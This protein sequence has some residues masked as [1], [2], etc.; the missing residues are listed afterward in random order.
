MENLIML[1]PGA[2][3]R[4][5]TQAVG[6]AALTG[7][8][9][10]TVPFPSDA[11]LPGMR[12]VEAGA[13]P[14]EVRAVFA[15]VLRCTQRQQL[16]S[17][18]APGQALVQVPSQ[19]V[20]A[21]A[22]A[23]LAVKEGD[24]SGEEAQHIQEGQDGA[25]AAQRS[26]ARRG[27]RAPDEPVM[28]AAT[29][30]LPPVPP[31]LM[32][33]A[34][35]SEPAPEP[36]EASVGNGMTVTAVS[37]SSATHSPAMTV[38]SGAVG[39]MPPATEAV[40]SLPREAPAAEISVPP[41]RGSHEAPRRVPAKYDVPAAAD[42]EASRT[43]AAHAPATM[44]ASRAV[45]DR[46]LVP[47][48]IASLP[49]EAPTAETSVPPAQ[50]SHAAPRR[51]PAKSDVPAAP[52]REASQ[53]A[54]APANSDLPTAEGRKT[55]GTATAPESAPQVA[56]TAPARRESAPAVR[57]AAA[58]PD[59]LREAERLTPDNAETASTGEPAAEPAT[60]TGVEGLALARAGGDV[61][62]DANVSPAIEGEAGEGLPPARGAQQPSARVQG[63][64]EAARPPQDETPTRPAPAAAAGPSTT[65]D[66]VETERPGRRQQGVPA[67][68]APEVL[69]GSARATVVQWLHGS[70]RVDEGQALQQAQRM[71][72]SNLVDDIRRLT[73]MG[74]DRA[75]LQLQPPELGKLSIHLNMQDGGLS[76]EM[77]VET[78]AVKAIVESTL[79]QLQS[80]LAQHGLATTGVFV[81]VGQSAHRDPE[82]W[83][84]RRG[85]EARAGPEGPRRIE[86]ALLPPQAQSVGFGSTVD[87]RI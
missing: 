16:L 38:A 2:Q 85:R 37:P 30:A 62:H 15:A 56:A 39:D 60:G 63:A 49:R 81:G 1:G 86:A 80:A 33:E 68:G 87:Y 29:T 10:A 57:A 72:V 45:G 6:V 71:V 77:V 14:P 36:I 58:H 26:K 12:G 59:E 46:P 54:A 3:A 47:E 52:D 8:P 25:N 43:V 66:H 78:E 22:I 40:A 7:P 31:A 51:V 69:P 13:T 61:R 70:E 42:R 48:A 74:Q 44:A 50:G 35:S 64:S 28:T 4:A 65:H 83:Q 75:L 73:F 5:P 84:A 55:G 82:A 67:E 23:A 53:T 34:A 20:S 41:A 11:S 17:G 9:G 27:A 19:A 21:E 79:D 76:V 18:A 32:Q 24:P